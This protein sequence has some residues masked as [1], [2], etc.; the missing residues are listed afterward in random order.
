MALT[1]TLE[2]RAAG[3][4]GEGRDRARRATDGDAGR[5]IDRGG[6]ID[7]SRRVDRSSEAG[8]SIERG[9]RSSERCGSID[10]A[11]GAIERARGAIERARGAID[12]AMRVDRSSEAGRSIERGARSSRRRSI[13]RDRSRRGRAARAARARRRSAR[14][15]AN[16]LRDQWGG[17][18]APGG[19]AERRAVREIVDREGDRGARANAKAPRARDGTTRAGDRVERGASWSEL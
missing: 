12:R 19:D 11:R 8:R 10:R 1:W 14:R 3:G 15:R 5:S 16:V 6:S 4:G 13:D 18:G 9:A 2:N 7:R 17:A